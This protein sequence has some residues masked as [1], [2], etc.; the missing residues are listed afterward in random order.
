LPRSNLE[1]IPGAV[2]DGAYQIMAPL[3]A[4][5]MA[6]VFLVRHLAM[7]KVLALKILRDAGSDPTMLSRFQNE[8][9]T[10]ARL[11]HANIVQVFNFGVEGGN[12]PYLVME[13]LEGKGLDELLK[14]NGAMPL[15]RAIDVIVQVASALA[16]A[17]DKGIVHR[18]M[19]PANLMIVAP[20]VGFKSPDFVKVLDFGIAKDERQALTAKG[21]IMGS[22]FY[23]SPEQ[24]VGQA[25]TPKSDIYSLGITFYQLVTGR[26]PYQGRSFAETAEMHM[27]D[28]IP[29]FA[30]ELNLTGRLSDDQIEALDELLQGMLA[31][32]P[33]ERFGSMSELGLELLEV[34]A[35][36]T[37][38]DVVR[39]STTRSNPGLSPVRSTGLRTAG[40]EASMG[41]QLDTTDGWDSQSVSSVKN[42]GFWSGLNP[43]VRRTI[44]AC[45]FICLLGATAYT[46]AG[47]IYKP[48]DKPQYSNAKPDQGMLV[49]EITDVVSEK[50]FPATGDDGVFRYIQGKSG[51]ID[52]PLKDFLKKKEMPKNVSWAVFR[53][54]ASF[55]LDSKNLSLLFPALRFSNIDLNVV[56]LDLKRPHDKASIDAICKNTLAILAR[57]DET[58]MLD[59]CAI[60]V[61]PKD[62]LARLINARKFYQIIIREADD[63]AVS[64]L[65]SCNVSSLKSFMVSR[66]KCADPF[67]APL[68]D[69]KAPN[70]GEIRLEN[71]EI[72]KSTL[73]TLASRRQIPK[74]RFRDCTSDTVPIA[75]ADFK[76]A[77]DTAH[78]LHAKETELCGLNVDAAFVRKIAPYIYTEWLVLY[79]DDKTP[80]DELFSDKTDDIVG[81][82]ERLT[83]EL[84]KAVNEQPLIT[85]VMLHDYHLNQKALEAIFSIKG[86]RHVVLSSSSAN[87][88]I[89]ITLAAKNPQITFML[90]RDSQSKTR[91][92]YGSV[93]GKAGQKIPPNVR[94]MQ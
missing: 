80:S 18:D 19:K 15:I 94:L 30:M 76:T 42:A 37:G 54:G 71:V 66:G 28:P 81:K 49:P 20:P 83:P 68:T 12:L 86:R 82:V 5:G 72:Y 59:Y 44:L 79:D 13:V 24:F 52:A 47:I 57:H 92:I 48:A 67:I 25:V 89:F 43:A 17:H 77:I 36:L 50:N 75:P 22:P 40:Y 31:K 78:R 74:L 73:K 88:R 14:T 63:A 7:D 53:P 11:Q 93:T 85:L 23:M 64:S 21:Q 26:I 8:A 16:L 4:G 34:R 2:F 29:S 90:D 62:F 51:E 65:M 33:A 70:L 87:P 39:E 27:S 91:A 1:L 38:K 61:F 10:I 6:S 41:Q 56:A 45:G 3:G 35:I 46:F 84:F 60:S 55:L 9:R 69:A 32:D 58:N